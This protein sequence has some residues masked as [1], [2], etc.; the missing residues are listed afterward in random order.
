M[1]KFINYFFEQFGRLKRVNIIHIPNYLNIKAKPVNHPEGSRRFDE[2]NFLSELTSFLMTL[3]L[4]PVLPCKTHLQIRRRQECLCVCM[5]RNGSGAFSVVF[6][7]P[8]ECEAPSYVA[9]WSV[10]WLLRFG[11]HDCSLT[12]QGKLSDVLLIRGCV[13]HSTV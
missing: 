10:T 11:G 2:R 13:G 5:A 3:Q 4:G 6:H 9:D 8:S 7:V 1:F 12:G